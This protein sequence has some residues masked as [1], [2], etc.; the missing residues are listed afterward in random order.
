MD[1]RIA[2]VARKYTLQTK[3]DNKWD[4]NCLSRIDG[5]LKVYSTEFIESI[6]SIDNNIHYV[7]DEEATKTYLEYKEQRIQEAKEKKALASMTPVEILREAVNHKPKKTPSKI[8]EKPAKVTTDN[9]KENAEETTQD[10]IKRLRAECDAR[11]L[12]YHE[13]AGVN[14]LTQILNR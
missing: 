7:I 14:K 8:E 12:P 6:N 13:R 9:S 3:K 4:I 10:K 5:G 11:G 1:H 2:V